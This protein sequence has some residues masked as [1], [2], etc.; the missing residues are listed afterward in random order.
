M[1]II[2][3]ILSMFG[4]G[5]GIMIAAIALS[6][7][8]GLGWAARWPQVGVLKSQAADQAQA[9][10]VQ[11]ALVSQRTTELAQLRAE[12]ERQNAAVQALAR[13]CQARSDAADRAAREAL[14]PGP[15]A[16]IPTDPDELNRLLHGDQP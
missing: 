12:T 11:T 4:G 15:A 9:L 3:A 14:R 10:A 7:G 13:D 8:V 2:N 16:V 5:R 6:I 1:G